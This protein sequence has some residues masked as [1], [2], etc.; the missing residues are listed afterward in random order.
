MWSNLDVM[1]ED[2]MESQSMASQWFSTIPWPTGC[3]QV[4]VNFDVMNHISKPL[5]ETHDCASIR[6]HI[7]GI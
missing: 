6:V 4:E 2:H 3:L 7:R 1:V 5:L